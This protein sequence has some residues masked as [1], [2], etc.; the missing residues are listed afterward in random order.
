MVMRLW[1]LVLP[2]LLVFLSILYPRFSRVYTT[3]KNYSNELKTSNFNMSLPQVSRRVAKKVF[4]NEQ[5]DGVGVRLRRAIGNAQLRNFT[6]FLM[7]DHF[8]ITPGSGFADHPHRGQ[9]TVTYMMDGYVEHEDFAGHR[10]VIGPGDIQWMCVGRGM[11]HAEMPKHK[12]DNGNAL[13]NPVGMQLWLDLPDHAKM[14]EPWYQELR[15][16]QMPH[17]NP[18]PEE[19]EETEG[20]GWRVKVIAGR[21]HGAVS[22]VEWPENGGCW[23]IDVRLEPNGWIFQELPSGWNTILYVL[24]GG[25]AIGDKDTKYT[26]HDTL[27]LTTP[28]SVDGQDGVRISNPT[29]KKACV[30][31]ISGQPMKHRVVQ[32]GPF[33]MTS[34]QE[35]YQAIDDYQRGKNGFERA[36]KWQSEI[37]KNFH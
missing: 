28:A 2:L 37:A 14:R 16:D 18:R 25:V 21:S 19:P 22:P 8:E 31:L 5:S 3:P 1:W 26:K 11:V 7:L 30:I 29:D 36:P 17:Q 6:P 27:V 32:Y 20:K 24:D 13:P 15:S 4:A 23:F 34:E 10:G 9:T 35:I 33:V 12:D